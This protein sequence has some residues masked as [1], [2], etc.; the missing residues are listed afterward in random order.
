[1]VWEFLL[2]PAA[3]LDLAGGTSLSKSGTATLCQL[4]GDLAHQGKSNVLLAARAT[5]AEF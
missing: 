3:I 1:M 2:I 4:P 5:L